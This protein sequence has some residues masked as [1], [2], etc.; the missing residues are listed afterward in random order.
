MIDP[1]NTQFSL[2]T[3]ILFYY[4]FF[5]CL[6]VLFISIFSTCFSINSNYFLLLTMKKS[7]ANGA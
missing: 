6:L 5:S 1:H 3:N 7:E 4:L 2:N